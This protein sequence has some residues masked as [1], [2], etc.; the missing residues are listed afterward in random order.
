MSPHK[1]HLQDMSRIMGVD[2]K[3]IKLLPVLQRRRSLNHV[4]QYLPAIFNSLKLHKGL[5]VLDVP[6]GRGGVSVPLAKKYKVKVQGFD[7]FPPY[8][9]DAQQYAKKRGV[10]K[11]CSFQLKDIREV[12]KRKDVYDLLLW[13][14]PP[15]VLGSA[16]STIATLRRCVKDQGIALISDAYLYSRTKA[17]GYADYETLEE[18]TKGYTAHGDTL[19]KLVD[20]RDKLWKNDYAKDRKDATVLL[21]KVRNLD[22]KKMIQK[23]LKSLTQT[24]SKDTRYLGSSIWVVR[25]NK[26]T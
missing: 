6:C 4:T 8:V 18:M 3:L 5:T 23:H 16:K 26:K 1:K 7:I 14:A 15:H 11:L 19:V 12:V 13:I 25:V 2:E 17:K 9:K 21:H 24:E 22:D 10:E 20:F